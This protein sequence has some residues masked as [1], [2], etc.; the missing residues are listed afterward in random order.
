MKKYTEEQKAAARERNLERMRKW[1]KEHAEEMKEYHKKWHKE[2][3]SKPEN[4]IRLKEYSKEY[5]KNKKLENPEE[6]RRSEAE[7]YKKWYND[8]LEN[9]P[10]YFKKIAE[11]RRE[12]FKNYRKTRYRTNKEYSIACRTS[13]TKYCWREGERKLIE[14]YDKAVADNF[15]GWMLHHRLECTID[16]EYALSVKDLKRMNMYYNRPYFELIYLTNSEHS[17]L[18]YHSGHSLPNKERNE[19]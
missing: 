5:Y 14:N 8:K 18:H 13:Q 19:E 1:H 7:K 15:K 12:Y 6:F 11:N 16:G 4:K 9:D 3:Y 17:K 10:D 2:H